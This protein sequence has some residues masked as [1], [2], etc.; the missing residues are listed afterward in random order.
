MNRSRPGRFPLLLAAAL[1]ATTAARAAALDYITVNHEGKRR[2]IP[3]KVEVEAEDGGVLLMARDGVLWPVPKEE[4]LDRRGDSK[5]FSPLSRDEMVKQLTEELPSG[6]KI[7]STKHYLICYNTSQD[8]AQ[9][10][11]ALYERLF[12]AFNNY[13]TRRG[14]ELHEP[15]FPLV[16]LVFDSQA[17]YARHARHELGEGAASIIGYYSLKTNRVTMYDL[18]GLEEF[19][20]GGRSSAAR[21]NQILSQPRAERTVATIVHEATHQIAFNSGLQVRYADIPFWVSEGIAIY[22]ETPDL[23]SSKGWRNIGGVNRLNLLN[24][25]KSLAGRPA[26]ALETLLTDD[27][28]FRD[29]A[30]MSASYGEAWALNYFLIRTRSEQYV[31]YLQQMAEQS[32]LV[33]VSADE[34]LAQFKAVFGGDLTSLDAEFVRYMRSVD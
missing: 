30:T 32:P 15:E 13:W 6:F 22:F 1:V 26:D 14:F 12:S 20:G 18:T 31:K 7:H 8:Y 23:Q 19:R 3:G 4:L 11:G 25:R 9:W 5:P 21:I 27:K 29:P 2:E 28:R 34:R 33:P 16:A 24:F 10:V 17:S